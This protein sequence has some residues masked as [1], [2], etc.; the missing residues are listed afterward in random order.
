MKAAT[1]KSSSELWAEF[2]FGVVGRLLSSPPRRGALQKEID[3]LAAQSWRHPITHEPV[4]YSRDTIERWFYRCR[5]ERG[6]V[7]SALRRKGRRDAGQSR[8]VEE[9]I[10]TIVHDQHRAHPSW[11]YKLHAD[12][13]G[14]EI[15][16]R[17]LSVRL[18]STTAL[19]RWMQSCGM[20]RLPRCRGQDR[21]GA[22][23]ARDHV[24]AKEVRSFENEYVGGLWHLDFHHCSRQVLVR[25]GIRKTPVCLAVLDD[26]SRVACHV[27]WY[28]NETT[29]NLVHAF[30]QAVQ[31]RGL[32][33]ALLTDNGSPM[34]AAEFTEGLLRL[35][36]LHETTLPYS[37]Y[38][39]GK[40]ERFFGVLEGRL[41]AMLENH[42][43]LHLA[44]L[45][46]ATMAWVELEYQQAQHEEIG[47]SP[48]TRFQN[49]QSVA[50]PS[51]SSEELK[52]AFRREV[53]RRQR[54]T[55]GSLSLEGKRFEIPAHYRQLTD[56][57]V[58]YAQWDL[59][60][61]HLV[62]RNGNLL[63]PLYPQD[64]AGNAAGVRRAVP[65]AAPAP[66]PVKGEPSALLRELMAEYAA[67]G[68]PPAYLPKDEEE[69]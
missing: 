40:Q 51:P 27:Q 58:R 19:R 18:P 5:L 61:V 3:K 31:K 47:T 6:T 54:R 69:E 23:A 67:T 8:V 34:T 50:R 45:N 22:V 14:A 12:N 30:A 62:D 13:L 17:R 46:E 10:K 43:E 32:P 65:A 41:M 25:D 42:A 63:C 60:L 24:T 52:L 49:S 38:Q 64:K 53:P 2:R 66:T 55:D 16:T 37:P 15:R 20:F 56:I 7:I 39:N 29:E 35:G 33:R 57:R 4:I 44:E 48:I 1:K 21:V 26:H 68:L 36:I 9:A 59:R 11:S 28:L